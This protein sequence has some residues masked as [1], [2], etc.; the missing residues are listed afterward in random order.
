[1]EV[2]LAYSGT[3]ESGQ[4]KGILPVSHD[5]NPQ[6]PYRSPQLDQF[7]KPLAES[8]SITRPKHS[9][10]G[11]TSLVISIVCGL[12]TVGVIA[13]AGY[14]SY[15]A[16]MAPTG[17]APGESTMLAVGICVLAVL[18]LSFAGLCLGIVGMIQG[19]RLRLFAVLGTVMNALIVFFFCGLMML[20]MVAG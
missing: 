19:N 2:V 7:S 9:G 15:Q 11:I 5:L 17:G 6:D 3:V 12:L 10:L 1:M 13:F 8:H 16:E 18:G 20:G 4:E 14:V